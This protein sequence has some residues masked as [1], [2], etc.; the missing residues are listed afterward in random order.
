MD[1]K[2]RG[3]TMSWS[4]RLWRTIKYEEVYLRAYGS[5]SEAR[6]RLDRYLTFYNR[7]DRIQPLADKRP[8][9]SI[10]TSLRPSWRRH[11]QSGEPLI[12]SPQTVQNNLSH[13]FHSPSSFPI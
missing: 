1:G 9:K 10:S 7:G 12:D 11:N 3:A 6:M 8:T 5:V 2:A 4:Q 13:L